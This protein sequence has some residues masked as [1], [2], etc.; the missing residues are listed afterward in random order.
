MEHYRAAIPRNR[1]RLPET[2]RDVTLTMTG[3]SLGDAV[4]ATALARSAAR[5]GRE[6]AIHVPGSSFAVLR[7]FLPYPLLPPATFW[8]AGD[9]LRF[10]FDLGNGHFIQRLQRAFGFAPDPRPHGCVAVDGV[11]TVPGRVAVHLEAG[12]HRT[13]QQANVHPRAREVYPEHLTMIERFARRHPELEFVQIG[14][15]GTGLA[16]VRD[17]TGT[18]LD[19]SIR[20]LASCEYFIGVPSGPMHLAAALGKRVITIVNFPPARSIVLP[21]LKDVDVVESEWLY[22]QAVVLHQDDESELVPRF[23]ER[24]LESAFAGEVYPYWSDRYLGLVDE[25]F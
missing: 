19:E 23:T 14:L 6:I 5:A 20:L 1:P 2:L 15:V 10:D 17:A 11:A 4:V 13:W 7:G 18:P 22:P 8:V 9:G 24:S 16:A 3:S 12:P 25:H 21:V